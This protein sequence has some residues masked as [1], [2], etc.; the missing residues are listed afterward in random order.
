MKKRW[1]VLLIVLT[2]AVAVFLLGGLPLIQFLM[3]QQRVQAWITGFG[4]WAPL[5]LIGT[6][7]LPMVLG[8]SSFSLLPIVGAYVFGF[9]AGFLYSAIGLTI[10]TAINIVLARR[11]GRP[12]VDRLIDPRYVARFDRFTGERSTLFYAIVFV[13]PWMPKDLICY[14]VGLSRASLKMMIPVA[15]LGRLPSVAVQCWLAANATTLP[16][17]LIIGVLAA[18]VMLALIGYRYHRQLE[19]AALNLA[20]RFGRKAPVDEI[21]E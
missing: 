10:G 16:P 17:G 19:V 21:K 7:V 15:A 6:L 1:V 18:G 4:L 14:A 12:L 3:D 2:V 5:V 13:I 9:W 11:F 8:I 20:A